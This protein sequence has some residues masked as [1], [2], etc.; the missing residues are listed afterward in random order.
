MITFNN[1]NTVSKLYGRR[2]AMKKIIVLLTV[3]SLCTLNIGY[4]TRLY[5]QNE[6]SQ[7]DEKVMEKIEAEEVIYHR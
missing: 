5:A 3:F 6:S 2:K 7:A 4:H 1:G